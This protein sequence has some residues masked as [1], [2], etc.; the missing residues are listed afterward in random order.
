MK[1]VL[2]SMMICICFISQVEAKK[3][4]A[5][6]TEQPTQM[7]PASLLQSIQREL[8]DPNYRRDILPSNFSYLIQ[9]LE[10]GYKTDQS[11]DYTQNVLSLFSKLLKGCEYVNSYVFGSLVEQFPRLLKKNF[12]YYKAGSPTEQLA[13]NDLDMLARLQKT[14]TTCMYGKFTNEFNA[15][16]E[17]PDAFLDDLTKKIIGATSEEMSI[18]SLR[19]TVVRFLEVGL[20]KLVWSA[21]DHDKSW[22]SLKTISDR[23]ATLME[24]NVIDDLNDLDELF[25][26]L[27]HRYCYFLDLHS[28]ELPVAFY[29]KVKQDISTQQLALFDLEEQENF[30][31]SKSECVLQTLLTQEAKR[32]AFDYQ[33]NTAHIA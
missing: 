22:E 9:L 17:N 25:W 24:C 13:L 19:Q 18:E 31:Q 16:K 20:S 23:I 14:V 7:T 32:R 30:I 5:D 8:K 6:P 27:V 2:F 3:K 26:T 1:R 29:E 12:M 28:T 21:H 33:R 15:F 11:R 10:Y 4:Q